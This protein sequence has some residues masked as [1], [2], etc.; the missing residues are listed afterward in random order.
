[1]IDRLGENSFGLEIQCHVRVP[2]NRQ[3]LITTVSSGDLLD[4]TYISRL[5]IFNYK[6]Y[7]YIDGSF[8]WQFA[9]ISFF[10]K[11]L[12]QKKNQ[13]KNTKIVSFYFKIFNFN[14]NFFKFYTL[15]F[16]SS[17]NF[18]QLKRKYHHYK[19]TVDK[20]RNSSEDQSREFTN[21]TSQRP[22]LKK[23]K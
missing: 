22:K 8:F 23:H 3:Q 12:S 19:P 6:F 2:V 5:Y 7:S 13:E 15:F 4:L 1:M 14:F 18:I 10:L 21:R 11:N 20:S 17:L 16:L 9:Q